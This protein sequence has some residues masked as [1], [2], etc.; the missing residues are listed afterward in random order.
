MPTGTTVTGNIGGIT[1]SVPFT[2]TQNFALAQAALNAVT[3]TGGVYAPTTASTNASA[4]GGTQAVVVSVGGSTYFNSLPSTTTLL[5]ADGSNQTVAAIGGTGPITVEGGTNSSVVFH[6]NSTA[7]GAQIF[8][9]GGN[10]YVSED[11]ANAS[12]V[13]N[14]DGSYETLPQAVAGNSTV[15]LG[16]AFIDA[17]QGST[18]V[19]LYANSNANVVLGGNDLINVEPSTVAGG[20]T[21]LLAITGSS[22]VPA[23]ITAGS[24]STL[25]LVDD[26]NAFIEPA[27]G[28]VVILPNSTGS[29][30]LFGGTG[31]V[32]AFTGSASVYGGTGYFQGGTAGPNY[33][34]ASSLSGADATLV[35]A[36]SSNLLVGGAGSTNND[37]ILGS[38]IGGNLIGFGAGADTATGYDGNTSLT[39]L[40]GNTYFQAYAD[41]T[42]TITDFLPG[43]DVFSLTMSGGYEGTPVSIVSI[44]PAGTGTQVVLSDGSRIN[45]LNATVTRANFT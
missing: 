2:S 5:I 13:I 41:G 27:G 29:A 40:T 4:P 32:P 42:D 17:H 37:L 33:L 22:T 1:V 12:A 43:H 15:G 8:L 36:G 28:N 35:G 19:N 10:N 44:T 34:A 3:I 23:T 20:S 6:N 11:S 39:G 30:T 7:P 45:F 9:G 31:T 24:G 16:G 38:T 14:V 21:D 18:T 25:W 26:A